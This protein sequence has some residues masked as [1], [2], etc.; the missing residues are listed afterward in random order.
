MNKRISSNRIKFTNIIDIDDVEDYD[1]LIEYAHQAVGMPYPKYNEI[2]QVRKVLKDFFVQYPDANYRTLTDVVR[3]AR[4][5]GKHLDAVR[6]FGS[7]RYAYTD[8]FMALLER[9]GR[10][11]DDKTLRTLLASV[12][13]PDVAERMKL[14]ATA[15]DGDLIYSA[16]LQDTQGNADIE[17]SAQNNFLLDKCKLGVGEVVR[18]KVSFTDPHIYGTVLGATDAKVVV[19][20]Q[21]KDLELDPHA[22]AVRRG[23]EWE[24][25]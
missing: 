23:G 20:Y 18:F 10:T 21:D 4:A 5:R 13:D 15:A 16:Y 8:G 14:A 9:G 17:T 7:W 6:L 11:N 24:Q 22:L 2:P 25:I 12:D 3:W 1:S 19:R